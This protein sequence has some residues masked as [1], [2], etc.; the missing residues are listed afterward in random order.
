M[1]KNIG[2]LLAP[3]C[4]GLICCSFPVRT[5][6][7]RSIGDYKPVPASETASAPAAEKAAPQTREPQKKVAAKQDSSK[8]QNSVEKARAAVN[9]K[10]VARAAEKQAPRGSFENYARQ[11]LGAKYGYGKATKTRTDCS[12]Y[13][14]QVYKGYYNIA[15]DHSASSMYKDSRGKSVSRGSL[16]EGDL[17]FFGSLWKIDHVGMY[18]SGDRFIHAST[19]KGVMI[20]PMHDKYWSPKY[21]GARRFK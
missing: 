12:G 11:W 16:K 13:V 1:S 5:G 3:L 6:Y 7:D 17:V 4:L 9:K 19:S 18:L 2:L 10:E 15:L 14:M 8:K 20:S 21:Q